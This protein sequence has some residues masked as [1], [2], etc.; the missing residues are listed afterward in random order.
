M[1]SS[2][3]DPAFKRIDDALCDY[4]QSLG[5]SN[6]RDGEGVGLFLKY[7]ISE[8]LNDDALP[9]EDELGDDCNPSDCAYSWMYHDAE[10]PIP[11][12]AVIPEAQKEAF[13]FYV[14][15]FCYKFSIPP[16]TRYIQQILIPK[17]NGKM[18][19]GADYTQSH[20]H[21]LSLSVSAQSE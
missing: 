20:S 14:L 7:V 2:K 9:I 6:Y 15:R 12:Y 8:E 21:S 1:A 16:T 18:A 17:C 5:R 4:Y 13:I 3:M 11:D 10:F 19:D